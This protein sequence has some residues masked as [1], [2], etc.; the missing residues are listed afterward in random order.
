MP[1][2]GEEKGQLVP[3]RG[4]VLQEAIL[5]IERADDQDIVEHLTSSSIADEFLYSYE[6]KGKPVVGISVSGAKEMA[7]DLGNIEVLPDFKLDK[8]SDPDYIYAVM[9]ARDLTRN[10]TLAGFGRQCKYYVGEGNIPT[11]RINEFAFVI[12]LSKAQRNAILSVAPQEAILKIAQQFIEQK[13]LRKLPPSYGKPA[14]ASKA[15]A[16]ELKESKDDKLKKLHQQIA[17]EWNKTGKSDDERK[18]WQA[19]EYSVESMT[20]LTEEQL[21][22]MLAKVKAMPPSTSDLGFSSVQEQGQ[23]RKELFNCLT[24]IGLDTDEKKKAYLAEK[25]V[26]THTAKLPKETLEKLIKEVNRD[27]ET[28]KEAEAITEGF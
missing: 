13:K 16:K 4:E 3:V 10:T 24:D 8:D 15:G 23:M 19:K 7:R 22:D 5:A 12:A 11:D 27:K 6:I 26:T 21:N 1:L 9:R 28:V 20:E 25:G 17:I 14:V 18:E 2:Y